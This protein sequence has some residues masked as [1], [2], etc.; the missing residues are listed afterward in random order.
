[1]KKTNDKLFIAGIR[2]DDWQDLK[3]LLPYLPVHP[4]IAYVL[5]L[6]LPDENSGRITAP[7]AENNSL[8]SIVATNGMTIE[9]SGIY[10]CPAGFMMSIR[11]GRLTLQ[12]KNDSNDPVSPVDRFF[13]DL[14]EEKGEFAIGIFLS[15]AGREGALGMRAVKAGGGITIA[16]QAETSNPDK[17]QTTGMTG[18]DYTL[19]PEFI[20]RELAALV[21]NSAQ[22][23]TVTDIDPQDLSDLLLI[24]R[25][26]TGCDFSEYKENT[27]HR[28]IS[29]RLNLRKLHTL[30]EYTRFTRDNP[31]ELKELIKDM[32]ISVTGFFRDPEA[33]STLKSFIP[34]I[35]A[36]KPN[37]EP[38]RIWTPGCASGEEAYSLAIL[39]SEFLGD[40]FEAGRLQLFATDIDAEGIRH[41]RKGVYPRASLQHLDKRILTRY[42]KNEGDSYRISKSI[43]DRIIFAQQDIIN[44]PPFCQLDVIACRNLLI[45]FKPGLQARL[46]H[47]FHY[48]L[49]PGGILF[50]G[51][52]ESLDPYDDLFKPLSKEMRIFSRNDAGILHPAGFRGRRMASFG[53]ENAHPRVVKKPDISLKDITNQVISNAFG[54]PSI[55]VNN[56][57][58]LLH[59]RGDVSRY[60]Q[61][62]QGDAG[63]N[64]LTLTEDEIRANLR[65]AV[66]KSSREQIPV[67]RKMRFRTPEAVTGLLTLHVLPVAMD[68]APEGCLVI[69]FVEENIIESQSEF[70]DTGDLREQRIIELEHELAATHECLQT[71]VE[72]LERTNEDFQSL[73]EELQSANEE[74]HSTNEELET[75]N[76]E[77]SAA[78]EELITVNEELQIKSTA[79]VEAHADLENVFKRMGIPLLVVDKELRVRRFTPPVAALFNIM[80]SDRGRIITDLETRIDIPDLGE[81]LKQVLDRKISIEQKLDAGLKFFEI[82]IYP[83]FED[84]ETVNGA[85]VTFYD[86]TS[87]HR[88]EQEFKALAENAPDIVVRLDTQFRHLYINRAARK[89]I[90]TRPEDFIGK[91]SREVGLPENLCRFWEEE[92]QKVLDTRKERSFQNEYDTAH[93]SR[94]FESRVA[95]EFSPDGKIT[96]L[97]IIARDITDRKEAE[98][99]LKGLN[100]QLEDI[101]GS[102]S[103][104]FF[105]LDDELRTIYFN[106]AAGRLL[107]RMPAEI[108]GRKFF[109]AIPEAAGSIFEINYREALALKQKKVFEAYFEIP[110][111]QNWYSVRVYPTQNGISVYFKI[112]TDQKLAETELIRRKEL[113]QAIVDNVPVL[114]TLYDSDMEI[115]LVN[116]AFE[117]LIGWNSDEIRSI[118]LTG[119]MEKLFPAK[120]DRCRMIAHMRQFSSDWKEFSLA[121]RSGRSLDV[122]WS[123]VQL[124]DGTHIGIGLD[125]TD[126]KNLENNLRRKQKMESLGTLA[127]GIAHDFNNCLASMIGFAE[128]SLDKSREGK[129]CREDLQEIIVSGMRARDLVRQILTFSQKAPFKKELTSIKQVAEEAVKMLRATIPR[130]IEIE[131]AFREEDIMVL[132]DATQI[133]QI[134]VNLCTNA[135]HSMTETGGIIKVSVDHTASSAFKDEKLKKLKEKDYVRL[136]VADSGTG[137]SPDVLDKLF[138]PY[139]TTKKQGEGSGL[140]LSVV[141]GIVKSLQGE[142]TVETHPGKG[143]VFQVYLPTANS[144]KS[145]SSKLRTEEIRKGNE[146]ILFVDDE[147]MLVRMQKQRLERL[148]YSVEAFTDC[149]EALSV[150]KNRPD[151]FDLII[152]DMTMPKMTGDQLVVEIRKIRPAMPVVLCTG[153]S[154]KLDSFGKPGFGIDPVLIKPIE[155]NEMAAAVRKALDG[156]NR[157]EQ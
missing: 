2:T 35:L 115:K 83:Y 82:K 124:E 147:P 42:F 154:E 71:T 51:K 72:E 5:P 98:K 122:I 130:S 129:D 142:I 52:S 139:F 85:L 61:F 81:M 8:K 112:T 111:Y 94:S 119:I 107:N 153:H 118:G 80:P 120:T 79:L 92:Y 56:R 136:S 100:H 69:S 21:Q 93:G 50:L 68:N 31:A 88:R 155:K 97:L 104:G 47:M 145:L 65:A 74:L 105:A 89:F 121:T 151:D 32:L 22:A 66:Y 64:I 75:S 143:T 60:F 28:R 152:T 13:T 137:I 99:K 123:T 113:F 48:A 63:L 67:V 135:A 131:K 132:G 15:G 156:E 138:D 1:M 126:R 150:F 57:L 46:I 144:G 87:V 59:V 103:D 73:N 27:L 55:L 116:K 14:A 33:F 44:D 58:E 90:Y 148:G 37:G 62:H 49:N 110:P 133:H 114:I 43:R 125:V 128:L 96:S 7:E 127:G 54:P 140:G 26:H 20:G 101:L 12:R 45:Y 86:I 157:A 102:I 16:E 146:K 53:L 10:Y 108:I 18:V 70:A 76:E 91:T 6:P 134:V 4:N 30:A 25:K 17:E 40:G 34:P 9:P 78:N 36:G 3:K 24:V 29:R 109:E 149:M 117:N 19:P 141:H 95:P 38:I 39:F 84:A 77:L 23:E 106:D 11:K 41:A